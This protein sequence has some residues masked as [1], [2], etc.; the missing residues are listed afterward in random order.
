MQVKLK[1]LP[2]AQIL[3][4]ASNG[5]ISCMQYAH[6]P[7]RIHTLRI[8]LYFE[9]VEMFPAMILGSS[10]FVEYNPNIDWQKHTLRVQW[11]DVA[12]VIPMFSFPPDTAQNPAPHQQ[13]QTINDLSCHSTFR[14]TSVVIQ[15]I[16]R[17]SFVLCNTR[18]P[19]TL[20][21]TPLS[22]MLCL[23]HR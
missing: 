5:R 15:R 14:Q 10:F 12:H 22:Q 3:T 6:V 23:L 4:T 17:V 19:R 16:A 18:H 1:Y 13:R 20:Q 2:H 21:R 9:I 11:K 7:V 8:E